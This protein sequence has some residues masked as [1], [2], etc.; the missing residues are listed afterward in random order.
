MVFLSSSPA[1]V[2]PGEG[3]IV[4]VATA[5]PYLSITGPLRTWRRIQT[6]RKEILNVLFNSQLEK[7][8]TSPNARQSM[9]G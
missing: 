9:S 3:V 6:L 2:P 5:F 4:S 7:Y 8:G 1:E